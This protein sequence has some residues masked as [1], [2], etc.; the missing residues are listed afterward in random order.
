MK[1]SSTAS[2]AVG[3]ETSAAVRVNNSQTIQPTNRKVT[4]NS[5]GKYYSTI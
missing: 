2:G 4:V 1:L 5:S 3:E